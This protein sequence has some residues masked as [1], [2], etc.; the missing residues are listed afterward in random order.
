M[1][2]LGSQGLEKD[3]SQITTTKK[4]YKAKTPQEISWT[5]CFRIGWMD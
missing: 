4:E 5:Q 2:G 1:K 3:F